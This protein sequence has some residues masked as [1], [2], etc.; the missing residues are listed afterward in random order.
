MQRLTRLSAA[1]VTVISL[2]ALND[3][4]TPAF[5]ERNAEILSELGI[6]CFGCTP[7]LFPELMSAAIQKQDLPSWAA[8]HDIVVRG[9]DH[10][11]E[12]DERNNM[13]E[14]ELQ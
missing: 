13:N 11:S 14:S 2:L 3:E 1:G 7:E 9:Q 6:P 12:F 8:K 4:G 5:S 10:E